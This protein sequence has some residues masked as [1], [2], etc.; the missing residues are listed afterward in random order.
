MGF[1]VA[2]SDRNGNAKALKSGT[3]N[4]IDSHAYF[5]TNLN[6][7]YQGIAGSCIVAIVK[8][9]NAFPGSTIKKEPLMTKSVARS[10]KISGFV[11]FLILLFFGVSGCSESDDFEV[12][13]TIQGTITD[14]DTGLPLENAVVT[15]SP[16][17]LSCQ[18]DISGA[19]SFEGIDARQY[20]LT[21][22]KNGYQPNRKAVIAI[23]GEIMTVNIQLT[24][25]P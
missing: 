15:L 20:T 9:S 6:I 8:K 1:C 4:G 2:R 16:S 11:A 12:F 24:P 17:G 13:S 5:F 22:Q 14:Y 19:Y 10:F 7:A 21:V 23:S 18:T 25:I 3:S